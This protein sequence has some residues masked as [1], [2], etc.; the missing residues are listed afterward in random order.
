MRDLDMVRG[1]T[2]VPLLASDLWL[3]PDWPCWRSP[4]VLAG[5]R[6]V[7][8]LLLVDRSLNASAWPNSIEEP[9]VASSHPVVV[10]Q[11]AYGAALPLAGPAILFTTWGG[12]FRV[13]GEA[14]DQLLASV[15]RPA[16][17]PPLH[18]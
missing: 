7:L 13:C 17:L 6:C 16:W 15:E 11:P 2:G 10:R 4:A 12:D 14:L 5:A 1:S 8:T 9:G 18:W 3:G